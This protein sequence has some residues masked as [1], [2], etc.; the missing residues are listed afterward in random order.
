MN[1]REYLKRVTNA[2]LI[3]EAKNYRKGIYNDDTGRKELDEE[4]ER[5][6]KLGLISKNAGTTRLKKKLNYL[7]SIEKSFNYFS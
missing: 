1:E 2:A 7:D 5:R 4:I 3:S 6:K